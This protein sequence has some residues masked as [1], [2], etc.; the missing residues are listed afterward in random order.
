MF[1]AVLTKKY[2][3]IVIWKKA[4]MIIGYGKAGTTNVVFDIIYLYH[5]GW[6]V[7]YG[8]SNFQPKSNRYYYVLYV[9]YYYVDSF[10]SV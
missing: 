4:A 3:A 9:G 6:A 8:A 2:E 5:I 7:S 1:D 10:I